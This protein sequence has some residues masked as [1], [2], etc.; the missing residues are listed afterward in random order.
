MPAAD[1]SAIGSPILHSPKLRLSGRPNHLV[2]EGRYIIP[3]QQK[4][5]ARR[6]YRSHE[7]QVGALCV[8]I[9][10]RYNVRPP[11]GVVVIEG[12]REVC[13]PYDAQLERAVHRTLSDMRQVLKTGREP[14]KQWIERTC[15][16]YGYN[17]HC[18][19]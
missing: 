11:Y 9:E 10:E 18:W 1:D 7:L 19:G 16:S 17:G 6:L 5:R 3:V 8:L 14:G 12:G 15:R 13:V 2:R 4:P